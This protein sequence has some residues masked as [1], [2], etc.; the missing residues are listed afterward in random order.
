MN[1]YVIPV[2]CEVCGGEGVASTKSARH[3][4]HAPFVHRDPFVCIRILEEKKR[5][6]EQELAVANQNLEATAISA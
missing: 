1:L 2:Y 6:F 4:F 5:K 3:L